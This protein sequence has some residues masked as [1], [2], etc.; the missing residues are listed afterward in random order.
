MRPVLIFDYDGTINETMKIY[1]PGVR[2][3]VGWLIEDCG[4]KVERPA[5]EKIASWLGMNMDDMWADFLPGLDNEL[6]MKAAHMVGK[7]ML[8]KTIAHEAAWYDGMEETLDGLKARGYDMA[9]LSN[10][11]ILYAQT[12]WEVF[13]MDRWFDAFFQCESFDNAPKEEI[14]KAIALDYEKAAEHTPVKSSG[15]PAGHDRDFILIGDRDSDLYAAKGA[16]AP[17][18]GCAYGYA[19]PGE[20]DEAD[21]SAGT[22]ADILKAVAVLDR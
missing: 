5:D 8:E 16:A 15:G 20:L 14:M 19:A 18:I 13:G 10:C 6:K 22:P 11:G 17:F 1:M 4:I 9:V 21:V 2:K 3:A 7:V 12:Q